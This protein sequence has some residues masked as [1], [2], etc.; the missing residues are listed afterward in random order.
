MNGLRPDIVKAD[1]NKILINIGCLFDIPTGKYVK[2]AKND[3]ILLGGLGMATGVIG[4]GNNF[5]STIMHYMM[6]SAYSRIA[7]STPTVCM[8]YDTEINMDQDRLLTLTQTIDL[9][10]GKDVI[11]DDE[12][13][14][15]DKTKY[16]GTAWYKS[17][18]E[19]IK[20]KIKNNTKRKNKKKNILLVDPLSKERGS[21]I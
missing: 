11:E 17:Y 5:K 7:V 9:L 6:L 21:S 13:I 4:I 19:W 16:S 8:T 14:I 12:W 2:G 10:K 15:T 3:S 20:N 18:R 1:R